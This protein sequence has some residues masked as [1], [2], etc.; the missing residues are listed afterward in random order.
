M[1]HIF[2]ILLYSTL[3]HHNCNITNFYL[4]LKFDREKMK[5]LIYDFG[6]FEFIALNRDLVLN[7]VRS[8]EIK[9]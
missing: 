9:S 1:Y 7:L 2:S 6:D 3:P 4:N 5:V 8:T